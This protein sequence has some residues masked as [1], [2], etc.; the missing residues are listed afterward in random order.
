MNTGNPTTCGTFDNGEIEDYTVN[1]G[2]SQEGPFTPN[3]IF[4]DNM[5]LQRNQA[6]NIFGKHSAAGQ[7]ITAS[8]QDGPTTLATASTTTVGTD[9]W[10]ISLPAMTEGGP[11][12]LNI[13]NDTLTE[14]YINVML[15]EV[16]LASG[17]SNMWWHLGA[18][19][20]NYV[21]EAAAANYP[22]IRWFNVSPPNNPTTIHNPSGT[23]WEVCN[24]TSVLTFSAVAYFFCANCS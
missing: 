5:V 14:T 12:T 22:N 10:E 24:P 23:V 2:F 13:A 20:Q 17:Q 18:D 16:W 3:L 15:G 9:D 6:I 7:T 11:Y 1:I 21:A 8:I 19:V 4:S